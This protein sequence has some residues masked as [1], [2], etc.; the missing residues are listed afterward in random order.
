[1]RDWKASLKILKIKI[2]SSWYIYTRSIYTSQNLFPW[3]RLKYIFRL[4]SVI[5][6]VL[7]MKLNKYVNIC[8]IFHLAYNTSNSKPPNTQT[9]CLGLIYKLS[10]LMSQVM[11]DLYMTWIILQATFWGITDLYPE[12]TKLF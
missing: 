3:H 8:T 12:I 6:Y 4:T 2:K 1:M 9:T 7:Q 11:T 5:F 10:Q